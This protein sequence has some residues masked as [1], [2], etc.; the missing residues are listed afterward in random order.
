ME[1]SLEWKCVAAQYDWN[2]KMEKYC[3]FRALIKLVA[4]VSLSVCGKEYYK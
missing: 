2:G 4:L 1:K 3:V